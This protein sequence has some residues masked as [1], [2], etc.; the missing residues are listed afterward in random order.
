MAKRLYD[1]DG[2]GDLGVPVIIRVL[3]DGMSW[4]EAKKALRQWYLDEAAAVRSLREKDV[5]TAELETVFDGEGTALNDNG[6][7]VVPA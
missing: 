3:E 1:L 6:D 4:R 2:N 7:Q 5:I